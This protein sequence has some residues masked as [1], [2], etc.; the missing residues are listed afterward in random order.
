PSR[1]RHRPDLSASRKRDRPGRTPD[2]RALRPLL[3]AHGV[4]ARQR[5]EDVQALG[6]FFHRPR[7]DGEGLPSQRHPL[8][9]GF[10]ALPPPAQFHPR[11]PRPSRRR[12]RSPARL[13]RSAPPQSAARWREAAAAAQSAMNAALA[14]DLNT[15]EALAAVFELV[16]AAN[17][18]LDQGAARA[19]DRD[20]LLTV[21]SSFDQVFAILEPD[22]APALAQMAD[23]EVEALV[24]QR[25]AARQA[26]DFSRADALRRQLDEAGVLVE[27]IKGGGER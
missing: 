20:A 3:D 15:A 11:R 21:F 4:P 18:A 24:A 26:R 8:P 17:I 1:R 25:R 22:A 16:R 23:T 7:P 9:A 12:P 19:A 2:P 13:P 10:R 5:R 27:D 14:D 6:Q